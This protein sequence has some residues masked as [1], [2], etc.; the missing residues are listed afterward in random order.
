[1]LPVLLPA[2]YACEI[3]ILVAAIVLAFK[4]RMRLGARRS[5]LLGASAGILLLAEAIRPLRP[6]LVT[7]QDGDPEGAADLFIALSALETV[8][9]AIGL[10][11]IIAAVLTTDA[12]ITKPREK[13][14]D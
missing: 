3:L 8:L 2:L 13:S 14:N 11:L 5:N 7:E 12:T 6:W 1:M 10:A 9:H 4:Q